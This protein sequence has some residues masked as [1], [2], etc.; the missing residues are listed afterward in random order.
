[1]VYEP[2]Y[3]HN[4]LYVTIITISHTAHIEVIRI[5]YKFTVGIKN[6]I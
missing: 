6:I 3:L 5:K 2:I 1:M 4:A